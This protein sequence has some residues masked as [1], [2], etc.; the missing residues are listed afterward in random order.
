[1]C[2]SLKFLS[3]LLVA[4]VLV[5]PLDYSHAASYSA[6]SSVTASTSQI[7]ILIQSMLNQPDF[8]PF[9]D[10]IGIRTSDY[11]Y[12]VFYNIKDSSA[13]RLRY[14]ATS[15]GYNTVWH[16]AKSEDNNFSFDRGE[17]TIVGNISD[18]LGS[19]SF[20]EYLSHFMLSSC[21]PLS[22][23]LLIFFIFRIKKRRGDISCL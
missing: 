3:F 17:Y 18:S 4:L 6:Y 22:C 7:N 2:K 16:F 12:S 8:N 23:V 15:S 5:L 9:D 19:D 10:W 14:Y 21:L 11:D 13:V 1:M 20:R